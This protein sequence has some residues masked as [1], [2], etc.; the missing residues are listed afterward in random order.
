MVPVC[1]LAYHGCNCLPLSPPW[2][3]HTHTARTIALDRRGAPVADSEAAAD[4]GPLRGGSQPAHTRHV[5][6][7]ALSTR[8]DHGHTG[9]TAAPIKPFDPSTD[10]RPC[11]ARVRGTARRMCEASLSYQRVATCVHGAEHAP[12]ACGTRPGQREPPHPVSAILAVT[13][14]RMHVLRAP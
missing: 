14:S 13:H 8:A 9:Q 7:N 3:T 11:K 2:A 4:G 12:Y 5:S 1:M 6:Y 10:S